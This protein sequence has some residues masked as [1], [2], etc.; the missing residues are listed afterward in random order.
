MKKNLKRPRLARFADALLPL[1]LLIVAASG[2]ALDCF[3]LTLCALGARLL[4]LSTAGSVRAAFAEQPSMRD[5]RG[6]VKCALLMQPL[7][8]AILAGILGAV[9][10]E[11]LTAGGLMWILAGLALNLEQVF[12]E[13]LY[14]A[15]DGR[16]AFLSR[17]IT[18]ALCGAGILL[19]GSR[20]WA[21]SVCCGLA[22][23][24]SCAVALATGGGLKGRINA[25]PIR[26]APRFLLQDILYPAAYAGLSLW[27]PMGLFTNH[28]VI[29]SAFFAGL[30][31]YS[32]CRTAF[33]RSHLEARPMN[34]ALLIVAAACILAGCA[35]LFL[36]LPAGL[37]TLVLKA[38]KAVPSASMAVLVAEICGF[39]LFGNV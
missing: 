39:A 10:R 19:A 21:V 32:L 4:A 24:A 6:S 33:R 36:T 18:A 15:G 13:Y 8:S 11:W 14:S 38:W 34:V 16:S 26:C 27:N 28:T 20:I 7:G 3:Y 2:G 9:S 35:V 1:S 25:G 37:P 12:Y 22:A 5:V 29:V 31:V 23:L 30:T 17:L